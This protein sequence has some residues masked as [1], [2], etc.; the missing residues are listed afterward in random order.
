MYRN[1]IWFGVLELSQFIV[2]MYC[3]LKVQQMNLIFIIIHQMGGLQ[4]W[5]F[6]YMALLPK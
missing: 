5:C 1:A 4:T 2:T 6:D 3:Y